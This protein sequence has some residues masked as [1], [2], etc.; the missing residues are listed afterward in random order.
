LDLTVPGGLGGKEA[1]A[2]LRAYDPQVKAVVS[3]G[4][5]DDPVMAHHQE[6][7]FRAVVEKPYRLED[8]SRVLAQVMAPPTPEPVLNS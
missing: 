8:L 5:S 3:S 4:Y 1:V 7:G 2:R 6:Y